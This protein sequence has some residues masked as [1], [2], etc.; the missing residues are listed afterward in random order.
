MKPTYLFSENENENY[1]GLTNWGLSDASQKINGLDYY[2]FTGSFGLDG[3]MRASG[4]TIFLY[5]N[6]S[7]QVLFLFEGCH[8]FN[9]TFYFYTNKLSRKIKCTDKLYNKR[10]HDTIYSFEMGTPYPNYGFLLHTTFLLS[11]TKGIISVYNDNYSNSSPG[12]EIQLYPVAKII[13]IPPMNRK[14]Q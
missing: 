1:E 6:K 2:K 12:I 14:I 13:E 7:E 5:Q 9:N 4:D 11:K 8:K 3:F 10:L